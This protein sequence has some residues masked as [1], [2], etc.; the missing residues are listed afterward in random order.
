MKTLSFMTGTTL[1]YSSD[2][3]TLVR[4]LHMDI[5]R[6]GNTGIERL[7]GRCM[8]RIGGF[9]GLADERGPSA[10]QKQAE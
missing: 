10:K 6:C 3:H 8:Q 2:F 7:Y 9:M 5:G 1:E 4:F